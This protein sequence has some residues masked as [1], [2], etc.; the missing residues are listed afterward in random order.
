MKTIN[1]NLITLA[2]E[3]NFDVIAHGC[4]CQ[5][6]MGAGIAGQIKEEFPDAYKIDQLTNEHTH[7]KEDL[8]GQ[9]SSYWHHLPND[10]HFYILNLYTQLYPGL[11]SPGC[12]IPFDYEA[13]ITCLRKVNQRFKGQRIGLPYIGLAGGNETRVKNIINGELFNMEVTLVKYE[14]YQGIKRFMAKSGLGNAAIARTAVYTNEEA[15]A[16]ERDL[17]RRNG[18]FRGFSEDLD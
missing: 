3:G 4:N 8:M 5:A 15:A 14:N 12:K 7:N 18:P 6:I 9:Y 16:R 13:F 1:G 10:K 17:G 2:L 11:P